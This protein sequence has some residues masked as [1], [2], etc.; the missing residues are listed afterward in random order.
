[1]NRFVLI[2]CLWV[3]SYALTAQRS[4]SEDQPVFFNQALNSIKSIDTEAANKVAFDFQNAW[5]AKFTSAHKAKI[6][7]IALQMQRKGYVI[8]PDYWYFFSYLAYS[9]S[10]ADLNADELTSLLD[11]NDQAVKSMNKEEYRNF[12]LGLNIFMAR[13]LLVRTKNLTAA[14]D[15]G[16]FSF[17]LLDEPVYEEP[18]DELPIEQEVPELVAPEEIVDDPWGDNNASDPWATTDDPWGTTND[19]WGDTSNNDPWGDTNDDPWGDNANDTWGTDNSD[20]W[21]DNSA[22]APTPERQAI[23]GY[24]ENFVKEME[25]KYQHPEITGP[26]IDIVNNSMLIVTPYDSFRIKETTGSYL[27]KSRVFVGSKATINW[28][29]RYKNSLGAIVTLEKYHINSDEGNFWTPNAKLSFPG[30]FSGNVEGVFYFKSPKRPRRAPSAYPIFISNE[31]NV[32]VDLPG[33]KMKYTGGVQLSGD[34]LYGASVSKNKGKLEIL[35]GRGNKVIVRAKRFVFKDST[36]TTE[37]GEFVILHGSDSITHAAVSMRYDSK[38]HTLVALR[39]KSFD[40]HPFASTYYQVNIN[41]QLLK[42]DM[43][44]DSMHFSTMDGKDLIPVTIESNKYYNDIR[45]RKLASGYGFHPVATPVFYAKKYGTNTFHVDELVNE[46]NISRV[47]A[48]SALKVIAHYGFGDFNQ[49]T[50][51]VTLND[52]AFHYYDASA[53][54]VDYDNIMI[55]SLEPNKPNVTLSLDSGTLKVRGVDS[56]YPTTDF[57]VK[58]SPEGGLATILK[59]RNIEFDGVIEAGDFRYMGKNH[60]FDY[61]QFLI[62]MPE[63][64]SIRIELHQVD[65]ASTGED[66]IALHNELTETSGILYLDLPEDK[67]GNAISGD[68]PHFSSDKDAVVYFDGVEVLN[69]AYDKSVK[70]LIPPFDE[71]SLSVDN[72]ISFDGIFNSGGIFPNFEETL[73]IMPDKSLGFVHQMP[74]QGYNLYGTAAKTYEK[75]YL[76]NDGIRGGGKIDFITSSIYSDDFVYY[77]DSVAAFGSSG[78]IGA[79]K[80]N[81]ASYPEA[82]LGAFRMHWLPRVDSMYL[83]NLYQPFKFYNATAELDGEVN[84]TSKGVFGSGVMNTR[85]STAKSSQLTFEQYSYSARHAS[86][87]VLTDNPDKPAMAGD[88]ISLNFDL[89]HNTADVHPEK[90]GVAAISFPYAQMKTSITNAVWDLEDSVVTMTKPANVPIEDSYFY[91]TRDEL[92]GLRFNAERAD[93]DFNT[94]ELFIQGIPFIKVADAEIIPENHQTTILENSE[95]QS[96]NNAEIIIDTTNEYHYLYAGN[97]KILSRNEFVGNALYRLISGKDTFAIRFDQFYLD[98]VYITPKKSKKMTVSGGEVLDKENLLISPGFYYKGKVKMYAYKKALEL[99]GFVKLALKKPGYDYWMRYA[100]KDDD[101]NVNID[102]ASSYYEDEDP[103]IAGLHYDLR[104]SVYASFVEKRKA[105]SDEDFFLAS[106]TLTFDTL[107]N[108]YKIESPKKSLG[109][110]YAGSTMIYSDVTKDVIFEG[111]ANFFNAYADRVKV[112]ASVLGTGNMETGEFKIDALLALD[113]FNSGPY[114][115]LMSKDL[116][117][118]IERLGPPLAN[119]ISVELLYKLANIT[120][121][122]DAKD[123]EKSSLKDYVPLNDVNEK[124]ETSLVISGVKMNWSQPYKSWY[125][126]TKLGISNIYNKDINAKLDGFLEI[127]KDDSN[128]DVLN[129]FI[130]AAPGTW[131]FISYASNNLLLYS[132]NSEFNLE[133]N[134]RSNYG[135]SKPGELVLVGGD[136]NETL[137]FINSFRERYF[138]VTEPFNLVYPDDF[139]VDEESNFDTIEKTEDIDSTDDA[140]GF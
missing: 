72:A 119:D 7:S 61:D 42:W 78:F 56:F 40:T 106:G 113:I 4:F 57:K 105:P 98:D 140:G 99:D 52:K 80:V 94:K 138:G 13:R 3:A 43:K 115:D 6:H 65:T 18:S 110:A 51:Q 71:D 102:L 38:E 54:K 83:Q 41:A 118:I 112:N 45:F 29:Q 23:Q 35:D 68:F 109:E 91:S 135:K 53:R 136:E 130:Q 89:I 92:A 111:K 126:T 122:E 20:P 101:P 137:G 58:V 70:F 27:L 85:G 93:Y 5:N 48:T 50:G 108:T 120:S 116:I 30:L 134:A 114:L 14:T 74:S 100:K 77:P 33:G 84:I 131:Y 75:I 63:V 32:H 133:V 95:L 11:I 79:G 39:D 125:N 22:A 97:I 26:I 121:D 28:P 34:Q 129:L 69:G 127:K 9:V 17:K 21:G 107:G 37:N 132:S 49:A 96:F 82:V 117:D 62:N 44:V 124:L 66:K 59:D 16:S 90:A 64:D 36:V 8:R 60:T 31:S 81:G 1:M 47:H 86:F 55:P 15:G 25:L 139:S 67:S 103:I 73:K 123:Y 2:L 10:Q 12:L 128:N 24:A 104:G 76:S 19:P 46:F 88:D 87:Q